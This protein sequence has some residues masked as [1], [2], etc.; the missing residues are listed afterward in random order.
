MPFVFPSLYQLSYSTWMACFL[1]VS[2]TLHWVGLLKSVE[3]SYPTQC[4]VKLNVRRQA[5]QVES[6]SW[7]SQPL[8]SVYCQCICKIN[9]NCANKTARW[10]LA[11]A[12]AMRVSESL[13]PTHYGWT[14]WMVQLIQ[15]EMHEHC[16]ECVA[17]DSIFVDNRPCNQ[18]GVASLTDWQGIKHL[19]HST[20]SGAGSCTAVAVLESQ[21]P[22]GRWSQE[23]QRT[24]CR[25][26]ACITD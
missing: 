10:I 23:Q 8:C 1:T 15:L 12:I 4:C 6:D 9:G 20:S 11:C 18:S 22:R 19:K 5:I 7:Q 26:D 14:S 16:C 17:L 25:W 24:D 3:V 21:L 13:R 2:F